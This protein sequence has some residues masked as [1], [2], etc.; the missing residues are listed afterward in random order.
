[1]RPAIAALLLLLSGP[2]LAVLPD[3]M[4]A[5]PALEARARNLS[6]ELRCVVCQN[7]SIDDSDAP[8]ARDLRIVVREQLRMGRTDAQT[9]DY[10]SARYGDFVLLKPPFKPATWALWAGP[11]LLLGAGAAGLAFW[12]RRPAAGAGAPAGDAPLTPAEAASLADLSAPDLTPHSLTGPP[13][14]R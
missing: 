7:Q 5:D 13:Q 1:M 4:L 10:V 14:P 8:L 6:K 2:A 12:R 9:L 11:F 3:E